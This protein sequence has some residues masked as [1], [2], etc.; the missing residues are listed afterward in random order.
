MVTVSVSLRTRKRLEI[1]HEQSASSDGPKIL[2]LPWKSWSA[3]AVTRVTL[4]VEF[5]EK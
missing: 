1:G 3:A 2:L 5:R 4:P